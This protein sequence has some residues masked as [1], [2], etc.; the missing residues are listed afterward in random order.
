MNRT[1]I[2]R[3]LAGHQVEQ[4]GLARAVWPDNQAAFAWFD[5]EVDVAGDAQSTEGFGEPVDDQ[6]AHCRG[7]A[8][9]G[10]F[11]LVLAR[12]RQIALVSRTTP[13]TRPSGMNTTIATKIAPS[14]KFQRST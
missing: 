3:D 2:R 10:K 1:G 12:V 14:M 9:I 4:R 6:S 13:G 5:I 8:V 7:P 11:A